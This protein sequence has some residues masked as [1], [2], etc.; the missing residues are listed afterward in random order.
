[1][2]DLTLLSNYLRSDDFASADLS[3][4]KFGRVLRAGALAL[5]GA[6]C[7]TG[8]ERDNFREEIVRATVEGKKEALLP[9][10][11]TVVQNTSRTI[12]W[13]NAPAAPYEVSKFALG[14]S[15]SIKISEPFEADSEWL[16]KFNFTI[17]N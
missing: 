6:S 5:L 4:L 2:S 14:N 16:K 1:M 17:K 7:S 9:L 10:A 12:T 11:N 8:L 13:L 3:Q 15:K